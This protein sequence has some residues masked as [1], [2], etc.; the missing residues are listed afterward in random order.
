M[1]SIVSCASPL[2]K[3]RYIF[4]WCNLT[5]VKL[6]WSIFLCKCDRHFVRWGKIRP[7]TQG[8][9]TLVRW[10][11]LTFLY[12]TKDAESTIHQPED[13]K[14]KS[15]VLCT[16][17]QV[18]LFLV[19]VYTDMWTSGHILLATCVWSLLLRKQRRRKAPQDTDTTTWIICTTPTHRESS[20]RF[21]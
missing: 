16:P 20:D 15:L 12:P 1:P 5:S 7:N 2:N 11:R 8:S 14:T 13:H 19:L 17:R 18:L 10:H 9:R 21:C 3:L 4:I 6:R